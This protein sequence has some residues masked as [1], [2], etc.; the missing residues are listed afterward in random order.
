MERL[1]CYLRSNVPRWSHLGGFPTAG[2]NC[3]LRYN[4]PHRSHLG[5]VSSCAEDLACLANN[6][7]APEKLHKFLMSLWTFPKLS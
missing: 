3:Y 1:G 5:A 6:V 4:V 7:P 2:H